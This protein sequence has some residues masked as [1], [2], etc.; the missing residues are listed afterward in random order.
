[1]IEVTSTRQ[2]TEQA[3]T[4]SHHAAVVVLFG[5][6]WCGPCKS[7]KPLLARLCD[8]RGVKLY[9]VDAD[10]L[11]ELAGLYGVRAV[12]TTVVLK[13]GGELGRQSGGLA[14]AAVKHLFAKHGVPML[15]F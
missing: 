2:F 11:R 13:G 5:A 3:I 4:A 10:A 8:E 1:M 15:E 6:P 7:Y 14:E 12:P 9:Y